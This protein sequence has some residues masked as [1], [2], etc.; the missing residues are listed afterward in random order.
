MSLRFRLNL[1]LTVLFVT[2]LVLGTVL[3][4][5]NA[6]RAV[7]EET[8][9][10][11][12]LALQLLEAAYDATDSAGV[13]ALQT[14]LRRQLGELESA[15]HL[16]VL[17]VEGGRELEL[18][19]VRAAAVAAPQWFVRLVEPGATELRRPFRGEGR[20]AAEIVVRADPGDEIAES[21]DDARPLLALVLV[22]S[23]IA[24][25]LLY[26]VIGRWLKPVERIVAAMDGIE[27]GDYRAR[28]PAFELPELATVAGKFNRMAEVLERSREENRHLAQ[29]SIAI[30]EAERRALAHE[31][32][33]ELG[34]SIAAINAVAASIEAGAARTGATT[35]AE[36]GARM[37]AVVRG[38][39]RRLRPVLLDEFGL[40]RA[41]EDLVD[42]W[43][44]R[45]ADAFC[46]LTVRGGCDDLRDD[47]AISLYR[48]V[49]ECLTNASKHSA[50]TE[51]AVELECTPSGG[52]RLVIADNGKGFDAALTRPGLGLLG[53]RERSEALGGSCKIDAAAGSGVRLTIE[54]PP[55][56]AER[57]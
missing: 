54:L 43:N 47:W 4:I 32:H 18:T 14:R 10:T 56:A 17:L 9:S 50:A 15:R 52:T 7:L 35:I 12:R 29:Q 5:G 22:V 36:I 46:R 57:T 30:Q 19:D 31:L 11:A 26:F 1:L 34:Q 25:G 23:I 51:V 6:R 48:I 27:Q 33:D 39:L 45:H 49:Q 20:A 38:M 53:M 24:N 2:I 55:R 16:Q 41:L 44:E 40:T 21:W 28:L 37:H 8:E 42:G 13:A 3:V